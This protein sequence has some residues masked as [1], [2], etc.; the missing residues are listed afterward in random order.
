M[1]TPEES[2]LPPTARTAGLVGAAGLAAV[3]V[4]IGIRPQARWLDPAGIVT[5]LALLPFAAALP[6]PAWGRALG[7][8]WL[9]ADTAISVA[10]LN[11]AGQRATTQARFGGHVVAATWIVS[12]A[13][14]ADRGW[15]R[16]L[17]YA[18]GL[19]LGGHSLVA[20]V[21]RRPVLLIASGPLLVAWLTASA[22]TSRAAPAPEAR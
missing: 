10:S 8:G 22:L 16:V 21:T 7:Y 9:A 15:V 11:G 12:A 6:A 17:G 19:T 5:H 3:S 1:R 2:R 4:A 13:Q 20:P 18:A 14:R